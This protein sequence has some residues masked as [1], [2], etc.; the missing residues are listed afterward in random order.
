[1][2]I[3]MRQPG[4]EVRPLVQITEAT[5]FSMVFFD[6]VIVPMDQVIGEIG[7]GWR[8]AMTLLGA[9]RAFAQLSRFGAYRTQLRRLGDLIGQRQIAEAHVLEE[10]GCLVADLTGIRNLSL[11]IASLATAGEEIGAL[12]SVAKLWWSTTHQRL[13]DLGYDVAATTHCDLDYWFPL[14]L[15]SRG[16]TIYAGTSQI[17]KNIVSERLLGLPR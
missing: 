16:E 6:D 5:D 10:F 7:D 17:Q 8:V 1:V 13:V 12:S 11:K 15:E 2:L 9:E 14:W 4:V 3:D